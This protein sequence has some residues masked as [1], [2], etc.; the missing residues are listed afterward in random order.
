M[1]DPS[2]ELSVSRP[3]TKLTPWTLFYIALS[4]IVGIF[5]AKSMQGN[6]GFMAR[7][8]AFFLGTILAYVG[9]FIGDILRKIAA[10]DAF[11]SSSMM[12][13]LKTKLFWFIGPQVIGALIGGGCGVGLIKMLFE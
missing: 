11:F 4:I 6:F 1:A 8:F 2:E 12:D 5:A 7:F 9:T 10:P 3:N 13:T